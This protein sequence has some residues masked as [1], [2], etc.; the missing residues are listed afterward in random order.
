MNKQIK[1][2][3]L[4]HDPHDIALLLRELKKGTL[5]FTHEVAGN[6]EEFKASLE[7]TPPDII[8]SDYSLP[9]FNGVSAFNIKEKMYPE[10]PFII[11]SGTVGEE[12]AV[13]LIKLGV[14]DYAIKDKLFLL[15]AKIIRALKEAKEKKEKLI[16][17]QKLV[18]SQKSLAEAQAIAH[19]GN[20]ETEFP[21]GFTSWSDEAFAILGL[22]PDEISPSLFAFLSFV[23]PDE[24]EKISEIIKKSKSNKE[25][26]SFYCRIIRKDGAQRHLY[27]DCRFIAEKKDAFHLKGIIHDVTASKKMEE[28]LKAS[29]KELETFI[30]RAS[31]DLRGPLSSIIGLTRVSKHE[32]TDEKSKAYFQMVETS[33]K[34]LDDTLISLVQSMTMRDTNLSCEEIDLHA[35]IREVLNQLQFHEGFSRMD[36]SVNNPAALK[37]RSSKMIIGSVFQNLIQNAIKYQNYQQEKSF[38]KI[39]ISKEGNIAKMIFE[40]NG[41]RI[42]ESF[43]GKIFSM[44][45]RATT[46]GSGSGLGLYIV[47][48]GIEKLGGT[49][50]LKSEKGSG[51]SFIVSLP[52]NCEC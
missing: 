15:N 31:H 27:T 43:Q 14:T 2:L 42:E 35:V 44:Y 36:I 41:I 40:D 39:T 17:E 21:S 23:H 37:I 47:K 50:E 16:A 30:Y 48:L 12:R 25:D 52:D 38:L 18:Q 45:F 19:I 24:R 9:S 7:K 26:F 1:I 29:N 5:H 34:K 4:E 49:I 28:E 32:I 11:V 6:E 8:L 46:S 51:S 10:V 33:A 3:L 13:E 20:W 22:S